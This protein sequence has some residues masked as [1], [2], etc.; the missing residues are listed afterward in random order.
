MPSPLCHERNAEDDWHDKTAVQKLTGLLSHCLTLVYSNQPNVPESMRQWLI[1]AKMWSIIQDRIP[2]K[3]DK[4][5][6]WFHH[7]LRSRPHTGTVNT[8]KGGITAAVFH[9]L[10]LFLY[11]GFLTVGKKKTLKKREFPSIKIIFLSLIKSCPS[12]TSQI[13]PLAARHIKRIQIF[14][15]TNACAPAPLFITDKGIRVGAP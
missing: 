10:I 12:K 8:Q 3:T 11:S 14:P 7:L 9:Y 15:F 6:V 1:T 4:D 13:G 5:K 2:L